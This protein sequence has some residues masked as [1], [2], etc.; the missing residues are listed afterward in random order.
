VLSTGG[1]SPAKPATPPVVS[2]IPQ[3]PTAQQEAREL[4]VWL[5]RYSG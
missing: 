3:A 2:V 1:S 5:R 4:A